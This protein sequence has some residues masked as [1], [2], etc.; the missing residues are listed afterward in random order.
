MK[1]IIIFLTLMIFP[2]YID[3][4]AEATNESFRAQRYSTDY[5]PSH[6]GVQYWINEEEAMCLDP[7]LYNPTYVDSVQTLTVSSGAYARGLIAM[8][9][10]AKQN[11]LDTMTQA[12]AFRIYTLQKNP[13]GLNSYG[14]LDSP[15]KQ[16]ILNY[17]SDDA[18]GKMVKIGIC[19]YENKCGSEENDKYIPSSTNS[20]GNFK[21]TKTSDNA[22]AAKKVATAI[23]SIV[24]Q[25][26][27]SETIVNG[28][29]ANGLSCTISKDSSGKDKYKITVKG[30]FSSL[31]SIKVDLDIKG[32][33]GSG[34]IN[35]IKLYECTGTKGNC[36]PHIKDTNG[37]LITGLLY[38]RFI[39]LITNDTVLT[40]DATIY[41][42]V[43]NN[44][45]NIDTST[46]KEGTPEEDNYIKKCGPIV[47]LEQS[48]GKDSCDG[49]SSYLAFNHSYVRMR[50]MK[51]LMQ[52]L[53]KEGANSVGAGGDFI[54]TSSKYSDY[55]DSTFNNYCGTFKTETVDMYTPATAA[56][57]SGQFFV[58]DSYT[59]TDYDDQNK[60]FRQPFI[61]ERV[62][63]TFFFHYNRWL[64][65]YTAAAWNEINAYDTWQLAV[66]DVSEKYI[67]REHARIAYEEAQ[68]HTVEVKKADYSEC[69]SWGEDTKTGRTW[70]T[71][72]KVNE[73][74]KA[75]AIAEAEANEEEKR[76]A[77]YDVAI[78][79]HEKSYMETEPAAQIAYKNAIVGRI[80]YQRI[81][82]ECITALEAY[83]GSSSNINLSDTPSVDF[84]Y[85]QVSKSEGTKE[86]TVSMVNNTEAIKYWPNV[87]SNFGYTTEYLGLNNADLDS[88]GTNP[89]NDPSKVTI[90]LADIA[91]KNES[92]AATRKGQYVSDGV[93][94]KLEDYE[95]PDGNHD[96]CWKTA[97]DP[98]PCKSY[99]F[100]TL[101]FNSWQAAT[102]AKI[103]YSK[104]DTNITVDLPEKISK[105]YFYRAPTEYYGLMNSGKYV[106]K[107]LNYTSN[108][109]SSNING[110]EIGYVYNI[111]LTSYQGQYT[112]SFKLSN[113]GSKDSTG[114]KIIQNL[115]DKYIK[116]HNIT[117]FESTCNYCNM[118]MAFKRN[119]DECDPNDP[120]SGTEEYLPQ[121]YY[122]SIS[123]SD[124]TPTEREDGETN[125]SD[126]KGKAA[127]AMIEQ[128]SGLA[129]AT[130]R[131]NEY[132]AVNTN[133]EKNNKSDSNSLQTYLADSSSTGKYD[134]YDD[135][136]KTYLEYEVTLTTKDLQTIKRNSSRAYFS[137]AEMNMC[138]GTVPVSKDSD[139]EYCFKC[140]SDMKECESSFVSAYFTNTTGR[141]KWK[142]Y[143]NGKFCTGNIKSCINGLNYTTYGNTST[144]GVY[145]DP[146]FPKQF[147]ST[148]KNWP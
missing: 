147:L 4:R 76:K 105:I 89:N 106:T 42:S 69:V 143:V 116:E 21:I 118:E 96:N 115:I 122:R 2:F 25:S 10:Y 108:A 17:S 90:S 20:K 71:E 5:D 43:P 78:P 139:T 121:F 50:N 59:S 140:N 1:K 57:V 63:T 137:Y 94:G 103:P 12:H 144:D 73:Q 60:Y 41:I 29:N 146:L 125:W 8:A 127:V 67:A 107:T 136:S 135:T 95:F 28:C 66:K 62:K 91:V 112:T 109:S 61:V 83:S 130:D 44:C 113:V 148:Y 64:A 87:T 18:I 39:K 52:D 16:S 55:L 132:V 126:D 58:F 100:N 131:S 74:K 120:T 45:D 134:I 104:S 117:S 13:K 99:G 46:L 86:N 38:Q 33:T 110:L 7:N 88:D 49:E 37:N 6:I 54:G 102:D 34:L 9:N 23:V 27:G 26:G 92:D 98:Y 97:V 32:N 65:D 82:K 19:A 56:S 11:N 51:Y 68:R 75:A 47:H 101:S 93:I 40:G 24:N 111:E 22:D 123:L 70:C 72:T 31:T 48:C 84:T 128:G 15:Y 142:Y 35:E 119:C 124:V 36:N 145:P 80:N 133:L 141:D 30:D 85:K 114:K 79:A 3:V 53:D 129:S 138:A 81:R 77:Y 14:P